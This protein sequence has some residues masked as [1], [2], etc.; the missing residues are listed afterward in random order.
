M[1]LLLLF[2]SLLL[3]YTL[4]FANESRK[5]D[6]TRSIIATEQLPKK[7]QRTIIRFS[8]KNACKQYG[9]L[10]I[11]RKNYLFAGN[12][13]AAK[14]SAMLYSLTDTCCKLHNINPYIW[15]RDIL[16]RITA[17]PIN[18]IEDLLPHNWN[19]SPNG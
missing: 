18:K 11:G 10:A 15:L 6:S 12:H 4:P 9:R 13:D 17:H 8:N 1:V 2:I 3:A 19:L 16:Q 5:I 7:Y 14:R